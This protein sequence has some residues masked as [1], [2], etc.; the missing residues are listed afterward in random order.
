MTDIELI[1]QVILGE[2]D[3]Y[4]II[5]N[6]YHNELFKYVYNITTNYETTEDLLQEVFM[7]IYRKLKLYDSNKS[8]FRTWMYRITSNYVISYLRKNEISYYNVKN[9]SDFD[10]LTE[11]DKTEEKI[12]NEEQMKNIVGGMTKVL[13]QKPLNIMM[14]HYFS[15]LSVKEISESLGIPI[16]TI[17]KSI[18][19][20]IE[21]IRKDVDYYVQ[22]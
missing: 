20:S 21:K 8:S 10:Y 12:I 17:Y 16:K 5:M 14:L 3:V 4:S 11:D 2:S 22:T 6:K 13:K 1:E 9:E 19:S 7:L 18:Q 15:G